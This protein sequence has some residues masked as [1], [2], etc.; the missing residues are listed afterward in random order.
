MAEVHLDTALYALIGFMI[1]MAAADG[2]L[3]VEAVWRV[4]DDTPAR[5]A[6]A[7]HLIGCHGCQLLNQA[8]EGETC[9]RCDAVL[10]DRKVESLSRSWA[11]ILGAVLLY[12]PANVYPVMDITQAARQQSFTI[13]GGIFELLA[14]HL[15]PLALLVFF[16]SITIPLMKLLTLGYM[17]VQT[18]RGRGAHLLGRTRA[19]RV[20]DFIG[21]WSMIDV[22][23][24]SILVALVRFGQFA[25]VWAELGAPCFAGVVVLTMFAAEA[26]DPRLMWDSAGLNGTA[27]VEPV[28]DQALPA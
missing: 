13:M 14:Y 27:P 21:R 24:I 9:R 28:P 23:M 22:F 17:L 5:P 2:S 26:F 16:A 19:F 8:A 20:I 7:G 15:W 11:F 1:S 6:R 12:I 4:L 25:N 10:H 18:Q 3:D